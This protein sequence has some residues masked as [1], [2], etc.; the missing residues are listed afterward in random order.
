L[1]KTLAELDT[2]PRKLSVTVAPRLN[3]EFQKQFQEGRD[4]YGKPWA[5]LKRTGKQSH[6]TETR[7]FRSG[8]RIAPMPGNRKGVRV[9]LGKLGT[10]GR[11]PIF[12]MTGTKSMVARKYLPTRGMPAAWRKII[13]EEMKRALKVRVA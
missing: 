2:L 10:R 3:A 6:L 4:P 1:K 9:I 12:H 8:S 7:R 11:N 13:R 5:K